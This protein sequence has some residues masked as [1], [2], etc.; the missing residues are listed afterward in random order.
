MHETDVISN[1]MLNIIKLLSLDQL[2]SLDR[3]HITDSVVDIFFQLIEIVPYKREF[4]VF[5]INLLRE[6]CSEMGRASVAKKKM[7]IFYI[8]SLACLGNTFN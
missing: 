2:D 6:V 1:S 7:F 5:T 4:N 3:Q 8:L